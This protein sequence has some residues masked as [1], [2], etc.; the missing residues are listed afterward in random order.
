MRETLGASDWGVRDQILK[1]IRS[2]NPEATNS[3]KAKS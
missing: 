2:Q 1:E 3:I